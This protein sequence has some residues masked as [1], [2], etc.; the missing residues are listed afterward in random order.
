MISKGESLWTISSVEGSRVY[1]ILKNKNKEYLLFIEK[2]G[3]LESMNIKMFFNSKKVKKKLLEKKVRRNKN[4]EIAQVFKFFAVL[5]GLLLY[6]Y[7]R[8]YCIWT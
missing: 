1:M 5:L 6:L 2:L 8:T 3:T 4:L 7:T